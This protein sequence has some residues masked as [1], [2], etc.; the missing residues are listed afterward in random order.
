MDM[1][2][3]IHWCKPN[4]LVCSSTVCQGSAKKHAREGE[5]MHVWALSRKKTNQTSNGPRSSF[6]G[7]PGTGLTSKAVNTV[8]EGDKA[9]T[10][11][12]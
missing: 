10:D 1:E 6:P 11:S 3:P 9:C 4:C 5:Q 12:P 7:T 8:M 2:A